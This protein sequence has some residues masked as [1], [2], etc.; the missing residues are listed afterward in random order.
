M[1]PSEWRAQQDGSGVALACMTA[2]ILLNLGL[3]LFNKLLLGQ[4]RVHFLIAFHSNFC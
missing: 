4:V 1:Q 3:T 2:Y